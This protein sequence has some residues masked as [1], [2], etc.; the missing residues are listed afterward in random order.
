MIHE[1][2]EFVGSFQPIQYVNGALL[3]VGWKTLSIVVPL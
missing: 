3:D 1:Q 2:F